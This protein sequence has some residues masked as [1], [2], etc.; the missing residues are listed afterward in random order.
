MKEENEAK[1]KR[2]FS[3]KKSLIS[4]TKLRFLSNNSVTDIFCMIK[5]QRTGP[6]SRQLPNLRLKCGSTKTFWFPFCFCFLLL[7]HWT[8]K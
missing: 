6:L 5:H 7:P 1:Q 8:F 3:Q 4:C 2:K